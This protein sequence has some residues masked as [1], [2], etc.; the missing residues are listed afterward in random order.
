MK[1]FLLMFCAAVISLAAHATLYVTGGSVTDAPAAWNPENPLVVNEAG[2]VYTFKASGKFKI[3]TAKGNWDT[4][5]GGAMCLDGD[6]NKA[7]TTATANLKTGSGDITPPLDGTEISYEVSA[8]FKTIKAT[9]PDGKTFGDKVDYSYALHGQITGNTDWESITMAENNGVWEWTGTVVAGDFGIKKLSPDGTQAAWIS[10]D[11]TATVSAAGVYAA[12]VGGTDWSSTLAG[13]YTFSFNP[14]TMKLTI[15]AQGT[16]PPTPDPDPTPSVKYALH[17]QITGN[18]AWEDITM[19]EN[20]GVWE[21]TGTVVAGEFGIKILDADL[22]Q[23]GWISAATDADKNITAVGTYNASANGTNWSST[24]EGEY[25]FSFNPETMMLTITAKGTVTPT[26]DPDPTPSVKYALHGTI[27]GDPNWAS[28]ELTEADGKWV[29]TGKIVAGDFG[30]KKMDA[31]FNQIG[32]INAATE[33]DI[34]ISAEGTYNASENGAGNWS[35]TLEGN[36]T[37][38]FDPAAL[39]LTIAKYGGEVSVVKSYALKG[40]ITGTEEWVSIPMT[41]GEDGTWSWTGDVKAGS[42]G[43]QYL[44]NGIQQKWYASANE[45]AAIDAP[46]DYNATENGKNWTLN[47]EGKMTFTYNPTT[48]LLSVTGGSQSPVGTPEKVYLVGNF[49]DKHWSTADPVEM[50]KDGDKFSVEAELK[51]AGTDTEDGYFS[52]VTAKGASWDDVNGS[53][54]YGAKTKDEAITVSTDVEYEKF[55]AGV[56]ASAANSWTLKAG[57]YVFTIDFEKGVV[58]VEP[59]TSTGV[60]NISTAG[61]AAAEY[62]NLQG[63][64]VA[65]P[66]NGVFIRVANGKAVKV[67][68]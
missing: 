50:T 58:R 28:S 68:R 48:L 11:G 41:E 10:A 17:G 23:T 36:Y 13:E 30:I 44:E 62:Y 35:S 45:A 9:L 20:N 52:F 8:D 63:V 46:G 67:R 26:P 31:D 57:K 16:V 14:E 4:F 24:L 32:W 33:N 18:S 61:E 19:T 25:T 47:L 2:G 34:N 37:L 51:A 15:T 56:N 21:W 40:T 42:F 49:G 6:W 38:T 59:K 7:T 39:T 64:R 1:K 12:K 43:V 3:S 53:D 27:T 66:A 65:N 55:A 29:W 54:R 60:E 5:N 22:N